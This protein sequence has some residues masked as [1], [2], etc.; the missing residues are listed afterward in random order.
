MVPRTN[1]ESVA[2]RRRLLATAGAGLATTLAGCSVRSTRTLDDPE[3]ERRSDSTL[4]HY[5]AGDERIAEVSLMDRWFPEH[6]W[7]F[8]VRT[9]LW[10]GEDYT[11]EGLEYEFRPL[12]SEYPPELYLKRPDGYP[13]EPIEF[14]RTEDADGTVVSIPDLGFQGRGSV[15]LAFLVVVYDDEPFDLQVDVE[16]TLENDGLLGRDVRI[17]GSMTRTIPGKRLE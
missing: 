10:H 8:P 11:T 14:S 13:W 4:L 17:E 6:R 5:Y 15:A 9:N 7:Q 12:D 16:A 3:H 1:D 2:S